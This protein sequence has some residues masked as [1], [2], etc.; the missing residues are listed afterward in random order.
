MSLTIRKLLLLF[1][2]AF[3]SSVNAQQLTRLLFVFDASNSMNAAWESE[4]KIAIADKLLATSLAE[5]E[6]KPNLELALRVY[7]C[8][9]YT[10]DAA[11]D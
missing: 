10:S 6:G 4:T 2:V 3:V 1:T 7:G 8:L 11:D 9:L 5:L